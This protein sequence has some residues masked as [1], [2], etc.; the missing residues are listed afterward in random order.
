MK[1]FALLIFYP[2]ISFGLNFKTSHPLRHPVKP[3]T[4]KPFSKRSSPIGKAVSSPGSSN[5][6]N[7]TNGG[8]NPFPVFHLSNE[9]QL[10]NTLISGNQQGL[11]MDIPYTKLS[12]DH[13]LALLDFFMEVQL[14]SRNQW[15]V[16]LSELR[17][18][19]SFKKIPV[20]LTI[21]Y[22]PLPLG[23]RPE[24]SD[25]FVR[26]LELYRYL[27][28]REEDTGL[29]AQVNLWKERLYLEISCF[30][31]YVKRSGEDFYRMPDTPPLI[32]SLKTKGALGEGFISWF[33]KDP[34]LFNPLQAVG[35]GGRFSRSLKSL[36]ISL[37]GELWGMKEKNQTSLSWY[38]F[39]QIEL[40]NKW[41]AGVVLGD[42]THFSPSIKNIQAKSSLYERVFQ[43]SWLIHP[44]LTLT[45]ERSLT[46]QRK[47]PF[48]KNLWAV[49]AQTQ[50]DF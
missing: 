47:G 34:A 14:L 5:T 42:I 18:T 31:G 8:D 33:K 41:R 21:G 35:G 38:I 45:I 49:R 22:L 2:F 26:E 44:A 36:K 15:K 24:N 16:S 27:M 9:M 43:I 28:E 50:F 23:Y 1:L 6:G 37:Q 46:G 19:H 48:L 39:S 3:A 29:T 4:K 11:F 25:R 20:K 10:S 17:L 7:K 32:V 13:S 40:F 12:L 30:G